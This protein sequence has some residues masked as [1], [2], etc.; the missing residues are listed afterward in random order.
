MNVRFS[1]LS[2]CFLQWLLS[3]SVLWK[4]YSESH[5][6]LFQ[7]ETNEDN[8]TWKMFCNVATKYHYSYHHE[9]AERYTMNCCDMRY[10]TPFR[11]ATLHPMKVAASVIPHHC[12]TSRKYFYSYIWKVNGQEFPFSNIAWMLQ[13]LTHW[14]PRIREKNISHFTTLNQKLSTGI[15]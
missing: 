3:V 4:K 1:F 9:V 10:K 12:A 15:S 6:T 2:S 5:K 13:I 7:V 14:L 8:Y 11:G